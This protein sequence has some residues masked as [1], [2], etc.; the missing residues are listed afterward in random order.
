MLLESNTSKAYDLKQ[1]QFAK[2]LA[3]KLFG[4]QQFYRTQEILVTQNRVGGLE[5]YKAKEVGLDLDDIHELFRR[6]VLNES[7]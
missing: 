4:A 7:K 5:M 6:L 1:I 2:D 3:W